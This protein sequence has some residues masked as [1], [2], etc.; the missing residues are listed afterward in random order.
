LDYW[1]CYNPARLNGEAL[2]LF[3]EKLAAISQW[4][5]EENKT[6]ANFYPIDLAVLAQGRLNSISEVRDGD[7]APLLLIEELFRTILYVAGRYP[8]WCVWPLGQTEDEYR[9]AAR[10]LAPLDWKDEPPFYLDMGFPS[11][12]QPQEYLAS[13]MWL[14]CKSEADPFKGLLK[15]MPILEAVETDFASPLLCDVV[16]AKVFSSDEADLPVD[17]YVI[18]VDRVIDFVSRRLSSKQLDLVEEASVLKILGYS[19]DGLLGQGPGPLDLKSR[20]LNRWIKD[21]GWTSGKLDRLLHYDDWPNRD[22][23]EQAQELI[24]LLFSCYMIIANNLM[25]HFPGQVDAQNEVLAPMA[26]RMLGRL[27][28]AEVT[29]EL[30]PS[31]I[32][33]ENLSRRVLLR[34]EGELWRV[35]DMPQGASLAEGSGDKNV[36]YQTARAAKAAA[37]LVSN[38]LYSED[39]DVSVA[40]EDQATLPLGQLK[41][42]LAKLVELFP[43]IKFHTLNPQTI[44]LPQAQGLVLLTFNFEE[45]GEG[46]AIRSMDV[47]Y[48]TGWGETRHQHKDVSYLAVEADKLFLLSQV[49]YDSCGIAAADSLVFEAGGQPQMSRAFANLMGAINTRFR[50]KAVI[51]SKSLID[52]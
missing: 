17:P 32:L 46:R 44:W 21:W 28:G 22:K 37:W 42:Y 4:A 9:E 36:L 20:A 33:R 39:L 26:A 27:G 3:Q 23:A 25:T 40:E 13:A 51:H 18:A 1:V 8:F 38:Q 48:R 15:I 49:L 16:K 10:E 35:Y 29:V 41:A 11:K 5:M 43:P 34:R 31:H 19:S 30:L 14:T 7:V 50:A 24:K 45:P 12:P 6:E 52:F 47:I 2:G